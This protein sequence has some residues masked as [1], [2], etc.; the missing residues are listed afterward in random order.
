MQ[1]RADGNGLNCGSG[2]GEGVSIRP[3]H[4]APKDLDE[5]TDRGDAD[6]ARHA[7]REIIGGPIFGA[8]RANPRGY[9]RVGVLE[10][11]V[12]V[13]AGY[14]TA[15]VQLPARIMRKQEAWTLK[16]K[17]RSKG[18]PELTAEDYRC[19][20]VL[21]EGPRAVFQ[22]KPPK[23][24]PEDAYNGRLC[25]WG[26]VGGRGYFVAMERDAA[27]EKVELISFFR[28]GMTESQVERMLNRA[29]K[30]FRKP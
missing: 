22:P 23:G 24:L 7:V 19:L 8:F 20:P 11:E 5:K 2:E 27:T 9:L 3:P 16:R 15:L 6:I 28:R 17:T 10:R 18:H 21:L 26:T 30:V 25:L 14:Q 29:R 12:Q 1:P 13:W 4:P